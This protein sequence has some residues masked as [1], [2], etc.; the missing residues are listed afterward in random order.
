MFADKVILS[1]RALG[2]R[3]KRQGDGERDAA[4]RQKSA[5]VIRSES[6]FAFAAILHV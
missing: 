3:K 2:R 6:T 1:M 4:A 5:N